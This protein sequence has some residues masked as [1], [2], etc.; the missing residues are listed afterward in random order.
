M[1]PEDK[2]LTVRVDLERGN[3]N[4]GRTCIILTCRDKPNLIAFTMSRSLWIG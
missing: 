3:R 4:K 2:T 1:M